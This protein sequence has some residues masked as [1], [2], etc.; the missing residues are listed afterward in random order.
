MPQENHL[1]LAYILIPLGLLI[2]GNGIGY[3]LRHLGWWTPNF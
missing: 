2:L 3:L 1:V